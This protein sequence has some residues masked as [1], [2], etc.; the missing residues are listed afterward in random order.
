MEGAIQIPAYAGMTWVCRR[1]DVRRGN[2]VGACMTGVGGG[3]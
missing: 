1:D 3:I 2:D